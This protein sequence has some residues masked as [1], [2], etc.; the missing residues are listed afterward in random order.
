MLE[1]IGL[2][3]R[4][5]VLVVRRLTLPRGIKR[6]KGFKGALSKV[7]PSWLWG[8]KD[9][10]SRPLLIKGTEGMVINFA[11]CCRPIPGDPI[12]GLVTAGRGIVIHV[13]NCKNL[14][15]YR[16]L[17]EKWIDIQW[18]ENVKGEFAVEIRIDVL[19]QRGVLATV[20]AAIAEMGANIDNVSI[21]ERDGRHSSMT[22]II[23]VQ[24]RGHLANIMRRVRAIEPV[25]R[26]TRAKS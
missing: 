18:E 3:N 14:G 13:E 19:N 12:V 24:G 9:I 10:S 15:D 2:G 26:I 17:P 11:K 25:S 6:P 20:A 7:M 8:E 4:M 5:A 23:E 16:R 22:M 1:D 21:E